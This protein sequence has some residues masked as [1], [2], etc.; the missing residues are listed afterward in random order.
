MATPTPKIGLKKPEPDVEPDWGFRL[1]ESLDTLD[2]AVLTAN[3][4][5]AGTVTVTDDG[6]GN[7]TISGTAGAG[8]DG[9]GTVSNA[10][11]GADGIT[12]TSGSSI[13]TLTGFRTE[14]VNAS[15][16]LQSQIDVVE[17]G[18]VDDVNSVT[19]SVVIAGAGEVVVTTAGQTITVSGTDHTAGG[20]S[21]ANALI[22]ADGITVTSGVSE[23]TITGFRTEFVNASGTLST[24]IDDDIATHAA[25]ADSHHAKYTAAEAVTALWTS[26]VVF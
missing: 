25:I 13:D 3:T 9:G 16:S 23:D 24:E 5:G 14:F 6:S 11:E 20:G 18:D 12:V 4:T 15:G 21:Q 7:V 22:G 10:L 19:G 26:R 8:G 17:A 2:D 1:N